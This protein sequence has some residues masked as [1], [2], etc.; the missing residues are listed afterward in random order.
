MANAVVFDQA[1]V[2]GEQMDAIA[3]ILAAQPLI[4]F[5]LVVAHLHLAPLVQPDTEGN[6]AQPVVQQTH[7]G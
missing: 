7:P 4:P 6:V 2:T 1:L 5:D 3:A